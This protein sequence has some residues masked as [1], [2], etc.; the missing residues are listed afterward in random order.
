MLRLPVISQS[1]LHSLICFSAQRILL[2]GNP[3]LQM[4]DFNR[5]IATRSLATDHPTQSIVAVM[6]YLVVDEAVLFFA[7][8]S[9]LLTVLRVRAY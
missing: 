6:T 4:K 1:F 8:L 5:K 2:M 3:R 7:P 9:G